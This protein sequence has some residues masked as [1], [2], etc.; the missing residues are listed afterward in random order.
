MET[1]VIETPAEIKVG[2]MALDNKVQALKIVDSMSY[3][4]AA[5]ILLLNKGMQKTIRDFFKPLKDA[6]HASHKALCDRENLELAKLGPAEKALKTAMQSYTE[7]QERKRR[8]EQARLQ[9]E[10]DKAEAEQR[11]DAERLAAQTGMTVEEVIA[12]PIEKAPVVVVPSEQPKV[13][14]INY[15][16]VWNFEIEDVNKLPREFLLPNNTAIRIAINEGKA[17][18]GVRAWQTKKIA[19]GR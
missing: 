4:E 6:A 7:E 13:A 17:I 12:A 2:I 3:Q 11:A 8:I 16:A 14:G 18:P 1:K 10:V 9:A 19:A 5:D 15:R